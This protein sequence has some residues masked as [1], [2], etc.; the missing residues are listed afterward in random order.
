[1][2][3]PTGEAKCEFLVFQGWPIDMVM[4]LMADEI[5]VLTPEGRFGRF[6]LNW[7]THPEEY[8]EFRW[9]APPPSLSER[10]P[11]AFRGSGRPSSR[12]RVQR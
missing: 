2:L 7:P 4:R 3:T 10:Q 1:M 8:E 6:F 12:P 5:E 11:Q 9:I